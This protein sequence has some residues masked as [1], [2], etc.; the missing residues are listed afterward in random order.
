MLELD[1]LQLHALSGSFGVEVRG[2][3][4]AALDADAF[5]QIYQLIVEHQVVVFRDQHL[6][7]AEFRRFGERWGE[8]HKHPF[9]E[10]LPGY[11]GVLEIIK[12]ETD[13][14]AF[15][16][17]WHSDQMFTA[18]PAKFTMLYAREVPER[19]GDT[20]FANMYRAYDSLSA[21]MQGVLGQLRG[22]NTGNRD[23]LRAAAASPDRATPPSEMQEQ[24]PPAGMETEATHPMVRT[25]KD[26]GRKALFV[27]G[28]TMKIDGMTR[29]ESAPILRYLQNHATQPEFTCRVAWEVG[30]LTIWDNRCVQHYAVNDYDGQR[31]RMHRITIAGDEVPV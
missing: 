6:D 3:N 22:W 2:V 18:R 27:G 8:I 16:N 13:R 5:D 10:D 28:H 15:G 12:T 14:Q 20:L 4:L 7:E 25:H 17:A 26:T 24:A 29:A 1:N 9:M 11:P 21:T 23:K 19:G 31:R 30:S